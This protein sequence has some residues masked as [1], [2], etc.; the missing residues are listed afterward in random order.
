MGSHLF[1]A[2]QTYE[3]QQATRHYALELFASTGAGTASLAKGARA[4]GDGK[5]G[6]ITVEG[7]IDAWVKAV[8]RVNG[9]P[10]VVLLS[11]SPDPENA[12]SLCMAAGPQD[13]LAVLSTDFGIA[14]DIF[15]PLFTA[16]R[17]KTVLMANVNFETWDPPFPTPAKVAFQIWRQAPDYKVAWEKKCVASGADRMCAKLTKTN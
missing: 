14:L 15:G 5:V 16:C 12:R 17:A 13:S 1:A 9:L 2:A 3:A 10:A 8:E 11:R 4:R 7:D 6:V